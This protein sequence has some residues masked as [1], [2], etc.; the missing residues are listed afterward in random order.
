MKNDHI[1]TAAVLL[2]ALV[3]LGH[4]EV[5]PDAGN[6]FLRLSYT[7]PKTRQLT[8]DEPTIEDIPEEERVE[9]GPLQ[10]QVMVPVAYDEPYDDGFNFDMP[11]PAETLA[12]IVAAART[13]AKNSLAGIG[14]KVEG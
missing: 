8:R 13:E 14:V 5:P 6:C 10:R 11:M 1:P 2:R 3:E 9:G 12:A 4:V 7:V